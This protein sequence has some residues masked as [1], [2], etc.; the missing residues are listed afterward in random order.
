MCPRI[1]NITVCARAIICVR[2]RRLSLRRVTISLMFRSVRSVNIRIISPACISMIVIIR[3]VR[4]IRHTM[5]VPVSVRIRLKCGMVVLSK[6]LVI[7]N[8]MTLR[9]VHTRRSGCITSMHG[10][11]SLMFT[12]TLPS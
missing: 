12:A 6:N 1:T 3:S 2:S 10:I 7:R 11:R 5:T 8:R 9:T 4:S